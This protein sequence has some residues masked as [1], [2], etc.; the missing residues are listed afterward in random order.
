MTETQ[1]KTKAVRYLKTALPGAWVYHPS[2]KWVSGIPDLLVLWRGVFAAIELKVGKNKPSKIQ[3]VVLER[4]SSAGA[5]TAVCW[6]MP[7]IHDVALKMYARGNDS[8][9]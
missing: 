3:M 5:I 2:D 8:K 9:N 6:T 7:E 1:L 4:L